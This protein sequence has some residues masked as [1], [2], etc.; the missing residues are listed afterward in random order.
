MEIWMMWIAFGI[1]CMI[2]EIFTPGFYFMSI[3]T[4]A[5]LTGLVSLLPFISVPFQILLFAVITFLVFIS[6][7]KLSRKL[8]SETA[9]ETNIF[10]LKGK[11]AIVTKQIPADGRGYVKIE[12]EEWSAKEI[13]GNKIEK[14]TK[15][16]IHSIEGNKVLVSAKEGEK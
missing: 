2:I 1:I 6:L 16:I 9:P 8:I 7:K 11:I 5:I 4:G 12:G 13:N 15:V 14:G 10:A 3:G